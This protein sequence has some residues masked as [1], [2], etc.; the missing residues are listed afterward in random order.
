MSR[1]QQEETIISPFVYNEIGDDDDDDEAPTS[2]QTTPRG[3]SPPLSDTQ[4]YVTA[5]E[6]PDFSVVGSD[7]GSDSTEEYTSAVENITVCSKF[8]ACIELRL[9][10]QK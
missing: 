1:K 2:G 6:S 8:S 3:P 5:L 4:S 7:G 10:F 9:A